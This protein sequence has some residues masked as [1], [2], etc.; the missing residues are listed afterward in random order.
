MMKYLAVAATVA[1]VLVGC[2][3]NT[4]NPAPT[5]SSY[6]PSTTGTY[7]VHDNATLEDNGSGGTTQTNPYTDSTVVTGTEKKKD[8][9]GVEKTAVVHVSFVNGMPYDTTYLSEDGAK[10]YEL[11]DLS[12]ASPGIAPVDLG[13]SWMLV[14]DQSA[15]TEWVAF[16]DSLSNVALD[17][18]G[19]PLNANIAIKF[20]IKKIG[21]ENMT[22]DGKTVETIKYETKY[23]MTIWVDF[24]PFGAVPIPIALTVNTWMGKNVGLVKAEQQPTN[25][26]VAALGVEFPI[27]GQITLLRTP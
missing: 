10:I 22:I 20:V 26:S 21:T 14:A 16:S 25:V 3:S 13:T 24:P 27:P 1:L 2:S 4:T 7:T 8:S 12:V 9:K 5:Y 17:Y 19:T 6:M 15:T 18:N 23:S 11:F